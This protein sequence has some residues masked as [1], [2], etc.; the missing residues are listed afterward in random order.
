MVIEYVKK[1]DLYK[2]IKLYKLKKYISNYTHTYI[3]GWVGQD[4]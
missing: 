2:K 1:Q 3:A 4:E